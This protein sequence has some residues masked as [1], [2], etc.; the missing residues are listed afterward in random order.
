[1]IAYISPDKGLASLLGIFSQRRSLSQSLIRTLRAAG[2]RAIYVRARQR[3]A[4]ASFLADAGFRGKRV[5]V[6]GYTCDTVATAVRAAG[7]KPV[8]YDA[9]SDF[10]PDF[11]SLDRNLT[12]SASAIIVSDVYGVS[13]DIGA[14][15]NGLPERPL[16]IGDFAHHYGFEFDRA[17][18]PWLDVVMFSSSYYKPIR[19]TGCGL[20][21]VLSKS[22]AVDDS[23]LLDDG[24]GADLKN[25]LLLWFIK[26][27]LRSPFLPWL[28]R[29]LIAREVE[30]QAFDLDAAQAPAGTI[31]LA[32]VFAGQAEDCRA[33]NRDVYRRKLTG[34]PVIGVDANSTYYT[35]QLPARL[36]DRFHQLALRRGLLLGRIFGDIAGRE[37]EG[38]PHANELAERV[39]NLP[40][41]C[42][43]KDCAHAADIVRNLLKSKET[44]E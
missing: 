27:V 22:P 16:V 17:G 2:A 12:A 14:W 20:L 36:R 29:R 18:R 32:Q 30:S 38:C 4:L 24:I 25:T 10:Q 44:H 39:L 41:L 1:M 33:E 6:P 8:F 11:H 3:Y 21:C 37:D 34:V 43:P 19:S 15:L 13:Q 7:A 28:Y 23:I 31:A 40:F 42:P 35:I 9:G 5:L 26:Q